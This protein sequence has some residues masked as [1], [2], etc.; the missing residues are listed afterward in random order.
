MECK[1]NYSD[2]EHGAGGVGACNH[3][4]R[5]LSTINFINS[6]EFQ[7]KAQTQ[8]CNFKLSRA[9][10]LPKFSDVDMNRFE[11]TATLHFTVLI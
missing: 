9:L 5:L 11:T 10:V 7:S 8:G 3:G 4:Y 6:N 2:A 1:A